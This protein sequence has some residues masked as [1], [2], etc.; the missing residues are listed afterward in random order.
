MNKFHRRLVKKKQDVKDL[1]DQTHIGVFE[2]NTGKSNEEEF[3]TQVNSIL[4]KAQEE[5]GKIGRKSLSKNNRFVTMVNAGSKGNNINIAQ[6]ISCLGQ[7]NVDGKRI[8]YG[9]EN[10]TLPHYSK[11]DD[12]PEARGFVGNSFIEGLNPQELYFHAMGGRVGLIDTAVKTSQTGYIQRRLVKGM[13]DLKVEYDMTVRNNKSKIIQFS[14]GNDNIEPTAVENQILPL[15]KMSLEEIY[16]HFQLPFDLRDS[17]FKSNFTKETITRMK[18]QKKALI[19]FT[20]KIIDEMIAGRDLLVTNVFQHDY[21]SRVH[22]PINFKRIINNIKNQ[23]TLQ[24]T[25]LVDITPL[26]VYELME[27]TFQNLE[28]PFITPTALLRLMYLFYLSPKDLLVVRR[29]NKSSILLLLDTIKMRYYK[30]IISPGEMVGIVSAQSIGEPTTQMTLNTFHF[31]GV[32]SKSNVTRGVP[33]IEEILSLSAHPKKPSTTIFL[34]EADQQNRLKAQELMYQLEH[35]NL[36]SVTSVV[37][38]CFDPD[39]LTTLIAEDGLIMQEYRAYQDMLGDCPGVVVTPEKGTY[40]KWIIRFKFSPEAMLDKNISM[41]DIYFALKN[42]YKDSLECIYSDTNSDNLVMRVRLTKQL[43]K[44]KK[45]SLD[46]TDQI[47]ML[48]NLQENLLNNIILRGVKN[49]PKITIRKIPNYMIMQEGNYIPVEIWVLDTMGTNLRDILMLQDIDVNRSFSND[50]QETYKVLGIEAA[51]QTIS[52]ELSEVLEFDGT[53][54]NSHHIDLLCD[55]MTSTKNMVSIFRHGINND[56]IGPLAKASFEETPEMFLRAARHAEIDNMRGISANIMCGQEG[57]F[58]TNSFQVLL[59]MKKMQELGEKAQ[60]M[61]ENIEDMM[62]LEDPND[63][64]SISNIAIVNS[65]EFIKSV[66]IG[67]TDDDYDI[68]F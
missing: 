9:F 52:N 54:I 37:S 53:Y 35:T 62:G 8:P 15:S 34:K 43:T 33:R 56:N 65:T 38:I 61:S 51:R 36:R 50:I 3:E 40:S 64:C 20:K 22:L 55:R 46:Q 42:S 59:D 2:N 6:M 4:N 44:K 24:K 68:G 30:S 25:S 29:F 47:Y 12:S 5:A 49:I 41:N 27:N 21:N 57:Y 13:E 28:L 10:R 1:I 63:L 19:I 48:K 31:A 17:L 26:E 66:A 45:K 58:G 60:L 16:A 11:Y 7:Q 32:A 39:N 67:D 18:K 23:L 14:Y